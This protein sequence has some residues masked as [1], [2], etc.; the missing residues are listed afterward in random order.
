MTDEKDFPEA[1]DQEQIVVITDEKGQETYYREEMVIPL[2]QKNFALLVEI[3]EEEESEN[4]DEDDNLVVA[5]IDFDQDGEPIYL[6][7]TD[8]EFDQVKAA[9]DELMQESEAE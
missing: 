8:E 7:P 2:G 4:D 5:R 3:S 9:Y 6:D 1:E